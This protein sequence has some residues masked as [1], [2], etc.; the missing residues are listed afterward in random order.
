MLTGN[1]S[2]VSNNDLNNDYTI[3]N[4]KNVTIRQNLRHQTALN[5]PFPTALSTPRHK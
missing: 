1:M 5:D 2:K 3:T 4:N